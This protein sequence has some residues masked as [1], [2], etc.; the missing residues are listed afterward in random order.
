PSP[1]PPPPACP[2]AS[3]RTPRDRPAQRLARSARHAAM[4]LWLT[5]ARPPADAGSGPAHALRRSLNAAGVPQ[6]G[7]IP[8]RPTLSPR[9]RG[10]SAGHPHVPALFPY[11]AW[12]PR[13]RPRAGHP[14]RPGAGRRSRQPRSTHPAQ[15]A[16]P[17]AGGA[18]GARPRRPPATAGAPAR[19]HTPTSGAAF[20][21]TRIRDTAS[22][23]GP[24]PGGPA[25]R[26]RRARTGAAFLVRGVGRECLAA[27]DRAGATERAAAARGR[28]Q[29]AVPGVARAARGAGLRARAAPAAAGAGA[30]AVGGRRAGPPRRIAHPG[31]GRPRA[32]RPAHVTRPAGRTPP[33][34]PARPGPRSTPVR[35]GPRPDRPRTGPDADRIRAPARRT[36]P[37]RA[38]TPAASGRTAQ[39]RTRPVAATATPHGAVPLRARLPRPP[40]RAGTLLARDPLGLRARP[41]LLLAAEL[42]LQLR[43]PLVPD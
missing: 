18:A 43:R 27:A 41:V 10:P 32:A 23:A 13:R 36:V 26:R 15:R 34:A 12:R 7:F 3:T 19:R 40:A 39:C 17:P 20:P 38:R 1:C 6:S 21:A 37:A 25:S 31:A 30:A 24:G 2:P 8:A 22:L 11:G 4:A 16:G 33:A 29:Q 5:R 42:P 35:G 14:S 28:Q 9:R